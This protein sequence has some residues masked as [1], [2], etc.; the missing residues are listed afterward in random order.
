MARVVLTPGAIDRLT[1]DMVADY[2]K[3]KAP[4]VLTLMKIGTPVDTGLLQLSGRI[5]STIHRQGRDRILRFRFDRPGDRDVSVAQIIFAGRGEVRP[6]RAKALRWVTKAGVVVFAQRS[7][8]V[9]PNRW[10]L[11]VFQ[12]LGYRAVTVGQR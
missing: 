12:Q 9:P 5:E 3:N 1:D 2:A 11:R 8:P 10:T 4:T 7:R 6:V